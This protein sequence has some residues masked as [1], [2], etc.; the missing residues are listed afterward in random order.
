MCVIEITWIVTN[1]ANSQCATVMRLNV[2]F[3]II[4]KP[5]RLLFSKKKVSKPFPRAG[6]S[7][8]D[9]PCQIPLALGAG[10]PY[11]T[12]INNHECNF[13]I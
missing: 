4:N 9:A 7:L 3:H 8:W 5:Y 12:L 2:W 1:K 10:D 6:L 11:S 13:V